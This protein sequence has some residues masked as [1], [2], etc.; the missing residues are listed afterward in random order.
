MRTAE[1][2]KKTLEARGFAVFFVP[3]VP[4]L[5]M[6]GGAQY[7][8][9]PGPT[10]AFQIKHPARVHGQGCDGGL[11]GAAGRVVVSAGTDPENFDKL[12]AFEE[13]IIRVQMQLEDAFLRASP[14]H[15]GRPWPPAPALAI[16]PP[17]CLAPSHT[18]ARDTRS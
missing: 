3:E 8:G 14:C 5:I 17:C 6:G 18:S 2:I 1:H 7:P 4:T 11:S 10:T 16:P 15:P 13:S 9:A 12:V